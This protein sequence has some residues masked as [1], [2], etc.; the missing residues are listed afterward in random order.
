MKK[1]CL[2]TEAREKCQCKW[3]KQFREVRD[4]ALKQ[5][6]QSEVR[7]VIYDTIKNEKTESTNIKNIKAGGNW[8]L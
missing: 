1:K 6:V 4:I 8:L 5:I 3:C 7:K 2:V